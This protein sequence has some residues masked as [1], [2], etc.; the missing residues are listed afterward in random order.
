MVAGALAR[1]AGSV[2][3]GLRRLESSETVLDGLRLTADRSGDRAC[4]PDGSSPVIQRLLSVA[5]ASL[6]MELTFLSRIDAD[7]QVFTH[8]DRDE[9][10]DALALAPGAAVE[11]HEG[12]CSLLL[13]GAIPTAVP[14]VA[15]HPVLSGMDVTAGL[16]VGAYCGVPVHLPD[17]QL[18]GTLCALDGA[19]QPAP[20]PGQVEALRTIARLVGDRL[21][22]E[23]QA[24]DGRRQRRLAF[25]PV[26]GGALRSLV[27]Q[28]IVDLATGEAVGY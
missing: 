25:A 26:L 20:R 10:A 11:P 17:G 4:P 5:R 28:P 27:L 6:G 24:T 1:Q 7:R 23:Q 12:Y 18:F 2:V 9:R 19:A 16:G 22:Y 8:V 14:D 15:A 13:D 3:A 21:A